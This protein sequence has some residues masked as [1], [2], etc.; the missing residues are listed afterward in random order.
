VRCKAHPHDTVEL[1]L[2]YYLR[3][4]AFE[5]PLTWN[6]IMLLFLK[7]EKMILKLRQESRLKMGFSI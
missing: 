3:L 7:V 5:H 4:L 1:I 6:N 2:F